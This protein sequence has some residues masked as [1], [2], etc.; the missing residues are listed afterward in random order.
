MQV[1][2]LFAPQSLRPDQYRLP[3]MQVRFQHGAAL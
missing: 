1:Q 3:E 2:K